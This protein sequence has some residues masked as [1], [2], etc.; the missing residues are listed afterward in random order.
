M[1]NLTEYINEKLKINKDTKITE[2]WFLIVYRDLYN[3]ILYSLQE[4]FDSFKKK[5]IQLHY[6]GIVP[7]RCISFDSSDYDNI[8]PIV[9]GFELHPSRKLHLDLEKLYDDGLIK[10]IDYNEYI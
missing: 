4:D 3:S 1:K 8:R 2:K 6:K 10:D 9:V 5:L 7:I